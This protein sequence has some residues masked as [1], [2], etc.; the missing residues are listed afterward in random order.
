M[1]TQPAGAQWLRN[2]NLEFALPPNKSV[3]QQ[4]PRPFPRQT[5]HDLAT[6]SKSIDVEEPVFKK[7][8]LGNVSVA[9]RSSSH[10]DTLE[11]P[12]GSTSARDTEINGVKDPPPKATGAG[13]QT[14]TDHDQPGGQGRCNIFPVRPPR[15]VNRH[16]RSA[17]PKPISA[18]RKDVQV[19][20]YTAESPSSAPKYQ[21]NSET[22]YKR[23]LNISVLMSLGLGAADFF[24]WAG[25]HSEDILSEL[26]TKQ[27]YYDK[28][29]V[30]QNETSTARPLVWSS[31]KH[32]S[33]LQILSSLFVS[34]L[35]QRQVYGTIT[36]NPTFKPPPRVT[37][38]D[39]KREA[40]LRDLANPAIPLRR[41]SRTI[42]HGIR[43]KVLLD[44]CLAKQIPT[45]RAIWLAKCV[46][47]NE[48]RAFKRKGASGAFAIGGEM[49]WIKDWTTNVEQFL[50]T[51]VA[52]CGA[53]GWSANINYAY[54][55]ML[56]ICMII[57][58]LDISSLRIATQLFSERLLD[59]EHYLDWLITTL[60]NSDAD[61]MPIWLLMTQIY[62]MEILQH[63]QR[64]RRLAEAMLEQ[65]YR[66]SSNNMFQIHYTDIGYL[67]KRI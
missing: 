43:G 38:T 54:G 57:T 64:G 34:A 51:I 44:H 41:L 33:G 22:R 48:I 62:W 32:K 53:A 37:L 35:D 10:Q 58:N 26:T 66:V 63:R 61:N 30:S 65:L 3:A 27:G 14:R 5:T 56:F 15:L 12:G 40:W 29:Q 4:P 1:T 55:L 31:L 24:P 18:P 42:P 2:A 50:E 67:G 60:R 45:T 47:A 16:S 36:T 9:V 7:Q 21:G 17:E 28:A 6:A 49:N 46:G 8:K 39:T 13:L 59:Q 23:Y 25:H 20:P 11:G 19:K 52:T